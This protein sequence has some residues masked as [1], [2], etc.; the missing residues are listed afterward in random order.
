[1]HKRLS[2]C[3]A[4]HWCHDP[5][6]SQ[7]VVQELD[8]EDMTAFHVHFQGNMD[9]LTDGNCKVKWKSLQTEC[10]DPSVVQFLTFTR[11]KMTFQSST[12]EVRFLPDLVFVP[13]SSVFTPATSLGLW[14]H[15]S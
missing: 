9:V 5:D 8:K 6:K 15:S 11:L 4:L 1:M 10:L 13:F 3:Q 12:L 14:W 2:S 7:V